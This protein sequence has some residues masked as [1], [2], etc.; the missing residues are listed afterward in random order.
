[1]LAKILAARYWGLWAFIYLLQACF[2][3]ISR[4]TGKM[5]VQFWTAT[6]REQS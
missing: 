3:S 5:Q 2:N 4:H 6:R 1:V